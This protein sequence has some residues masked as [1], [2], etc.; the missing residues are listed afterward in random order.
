MQCSRC[1]NPAI[2]F[3]RYSGRHLCSEHLIV[4]ITTRAK[5]VIRQHHWLVKGDHIGVYTGFGFGETLYLFLEDLVA[6]RS[7]ITLSRIEEPD[8]RFTDE[9]TRH[10]TFSDLISSSGITRIAFPDS[11][12]DIATGILSSLLTGDIESILTGGETDHGMA[13]M[14]PFREI[15]DEELEIYTRKFGI[16]RSEHPGDSNA[17][18][19]FHHAVRGL[20]ATYS[21]SHP[22][23]LHSLRRYGDALH[24]LAMKE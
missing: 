11:A 1:L 20:L 3:Q 8:P 13:V 18:P 5:R 2:L 21:V 15:P 10:Q 22:S 9:T 6:N 7:D 24:V 4:D 17:T 19:L 14:Y 23:V 16:I 12:D